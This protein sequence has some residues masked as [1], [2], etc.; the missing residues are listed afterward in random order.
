M[1]SKW[2][3]FDLIAHVSHRPP[4]AHFESATRRALN[5][6]QQVS[7]PTMLSIFNNK[8]LKVKQVDN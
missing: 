5:K 8:E 6:L 7:D 3:M 4:A 1:T 2:R